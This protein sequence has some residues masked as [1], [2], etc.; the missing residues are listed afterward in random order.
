MISELFLNDILINVISYLLAGPLKQKMYKK[1]KFQK[2]LN[3]KTI[4]TL[5]DAKT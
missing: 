1:Q 2:L 5:G 4:K 3:G